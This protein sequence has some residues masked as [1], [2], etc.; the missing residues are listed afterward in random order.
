[1]GLILNPLGARMA[2]ILKL[3]HVERRIWSS[4]ARLKDSAGDAGERPQV[5]LLS[6]PA[7]V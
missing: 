4:A 1:M 5:Q 7:S 3:L 2:L 6:R